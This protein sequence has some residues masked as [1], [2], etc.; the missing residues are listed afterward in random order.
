M[1]VEEV[2]DDGVEGVTAKEAAPGGLGRRGSWSWGRYCGFP[3]T[4]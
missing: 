3:A 1:A 4:A 2:G